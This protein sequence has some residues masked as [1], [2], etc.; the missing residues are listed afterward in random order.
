MLSIQAKH[1]IS[2]AQFSQCV[3][4]VNYD[5]KKFTNV[6]SLKSNYIWDN[7]MPLLLPNL[8]HYLY[9]ND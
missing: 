5:M 4:K 2:T 8:L 1:Y 9:S 3:Y 6:Y 7:R